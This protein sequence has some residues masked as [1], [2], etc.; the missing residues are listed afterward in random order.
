MWAK[1]EEGGTRRGGGGGLGRCRLPPAVGGRGRLGVGHGYG[2][3]EGV[4][5]GKKE[6]EGRR[7]TVPEKPAEEAEAEW[8]VR[9]TSV[10]E[11][12]ARGSMGGE[13]KRKIRKF[14]FY[15]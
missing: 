13:G 9:H 14:Y 2:D 7:G 15:P 11:D 5:D 4:A 6:R 8:A 1:E 10:V 3:V 12:L